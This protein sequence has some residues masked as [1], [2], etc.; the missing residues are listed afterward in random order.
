[1]F[2]CAAVCHFFCILHSLCHVLKGCTD[3]GGESVAREYAD[4]KLQYCCGRYGAMHDVAE[5]IKQRLA[6]VPENA[7]LK[8]EVGPDQVADIVSR[9][10]GIPVTK[11][12]QGE[13][14]RLLQLKDE[15]HKRVV[16]QDKAVQVL[17]CCCLAMFCNDA[18][19]KVWQQQLAFTC[20]EIHADVQP[21]K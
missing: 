21:L 20:C 19:S 16:G 1:M 9:W 17:P 8:E 3:R 18:C 15:L 12:Q 4:A 7:M 13:R 5:A 14:D 11:L 10:T 6:E 2:S